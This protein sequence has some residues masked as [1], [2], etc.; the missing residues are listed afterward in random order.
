MEKV[1]PKQILELIRKLPD[2]ES[3]IHIFQSEFCVT[4]E[5]L[6]G[7]F[8][9]RVFGSYT[10]FEDSAQQL[11]DYLYSH[12][13]HES[14]VGIRVTESGFPDLEKVLIYC[15]PKEIIEE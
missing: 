2:S 4:T 11:I 6:V 15:T 5:W 10:S 3:H 13:S 8:A 14:M 9:G 1:T 12:I 7:N